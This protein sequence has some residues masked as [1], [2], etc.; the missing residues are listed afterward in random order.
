MVRRPDCLLQGEDARLI[1]VAKE[2]NVENRLL[3]PVLATMAI[4]PEFART[5]LKPMGISVGKTTKIRVLTEVKFA[6]FEK[7]NFRIDGLIILTTGKK[8]HNILVEAKARSNDLDLKQIEDYLQVARANGIQTLITISNQFTANPTHS[9][10]K[11]RKALLNK[12]E[13]Y[14]I[15]WSA[16]ATNVDLILGMGS[17]DDKERRLILSELQKFLSHPYSGVS[18][19]T[20]MNKGWR[21]IV[22]EFSSGAVPRKTDADLLETIDTWHQ[23]QKDMCL[24]LSRHL[25]TRV[26]L[27]LPKR[28]RDSAAEWQKT[29]LETLL[30]SYNLK[31]VIEVPAAAAPIDIE[32]NLARKTISF[33]MRLGVPTDRVSNKA[34]C[35]WLVRQLKSADDDRLAI[36]LHFQRNKSVVQIDLAKL[37][38]QPELADSTDAQVK[39]LEIRLHVELAGDF[40]GSRKFIE[41]LE[42]DLIIFY[43]QAASNIKN[44]QPAAPKSIDKPTSKTVEM[45]TK[46]SLSNPGDLN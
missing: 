22:K 33:S 19:L 6:K 17:I 32:A 40:S 9:P 26:T 3:S 41:K 12:V 7:E 39:H 1:P 30:A 24:I 16:L 5:I 8:V 10:V 11:V 43:D 18:G 42:K 31:S 29:S 21:N 36:R 23:Q 38:E 20:Q 44:W 14:H 2:S 45:N 13:L 28:H 37:R 4:V 34:R 25:Q 15:S 46:S 35:S 27:K